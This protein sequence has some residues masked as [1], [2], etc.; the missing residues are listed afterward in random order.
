MWESPA[1]CFSYTHSHGSLFSTLAS[2]K[3]AAESLGPVK[4]Y[5]ASEKTTQQF[6]RQF[7]QQVIHILLEPIDRNYIEEHLKGAILIP[8]GSLQL[9]EPKKYPVLV[10]VKGLTITLFDLQDKDARTVLSTIQQLEKK[11]TTMVSS[12]VEDLASEEFPPLPKATTIQNTNKPSRIVAE[13][14]KPAVA[15]KA[16]IAQSRKKLNYKHP[17]IH[18][19]ACQYLKT[20]RD[21]C[22]FYH[23][24]AELA[25]AAKNNFKS[26]IHIPP[27]MVGWVLGTNGAT[28]EEMVR[29]SGA[30]MWIK[31]HTK[32]DCVMH[33]TGS[34]QAV[35][36]GEK[37]VKDKI[38]KYDASTAPVVDK[39]EK[40]GTKVVS[41][42]VVKEAKSSASSIPPARPSTFGQSLLEWA[43]VA[44]NPPPTVPNLRVST[45]EPVQQQQVELTPL[46]PGDTIRRQLTNHQVMNQQVTQHA[47]LPE[48]STLSA[49]VGHVSHTNIF[50]MVP[51]EPMVDKL[52]SP[53]LNSNLCILTSEPGRQ[54]RVGP[55]VLTPGDTSSSDHFSRLPTSVS[56]WNQQV[57]HYGVMPDTR[58]S[59]A[60][61]SRVSPAGASW[62][63]IA[64]PSLPTPVTPTPMNDTLFT[65]LKE[66]KECLKGSPEAFYRWLVDTE[67]VTSLDDLVDAMSQDAYLRDV[68]QPGNGTVGVKGFKLAIFEK[69]AMDA[70]NC[71]FDNGPNLEA[72]KEHRDPSF[73]LICPISYSLMTDD[74]VIAADGHTYERAAIE[75]W[76][77]K[78]QAEISVAMR[79]LS[80]GSNSQQALA[81]VQRGVLSPLTHEKMAHL[82]L[83]PNHALR[84][85]AKDT[86]LN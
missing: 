5:L 30:K 36:A 79:Q 80:M 25:Q 84:A 70:A 54:Q 74:P 53:P 55:L 68:L 10:R 85:L 35:D 61:I 75:M 56:L 14:P 13:A 43:K 50:S 22:R 12:F 42:S 23:S 16:T 4:D 2:L 72:D 60:P 31:T 15:S 33:I 67:D 49:P 11:G 63:V 9:V 39:K 83:I 29:K 28:I 18:G 44:K 71:A 32:G 45:T 26:V 62:K 8:E 57:T 69:A 76:F 81:I 46:A 17:C 82:H 7:M 6:V 20:G 3:A 59:S 65:F 78:Q 24:T 47:V 1:S 21:E 19:A 77:Q 66:Q 40:K 27:N 41:S 37:M 73:E 48:T 58:V 38:A 64:P 86:S 52:S 51:H 34:H